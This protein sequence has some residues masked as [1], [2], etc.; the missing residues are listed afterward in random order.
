MP[1][2]LV[3][4]GRAAATVR[5]TTP[6]P[7]SVPL[8]TGPLSRHDLERLAETAAGELIAGDVGTIARLFKSIRSPVPGIRWEPAETDIARGELRF[9]LRLWS[10]RAERGSLPPSW[11]IDPI[12]LRPA[13]GYLMLLEPVD[14]GA[15]FRYRLYGSL[16]AEHS[17]L[18]M[19]GKSVWDIPSGPVAVYLLAT[20]RAVLRARRPMLA[21]HTTHHDIQ[22]AD[23]SRLILPFA[24]EDGGVDRLLVGNVPTLRPA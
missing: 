4:P 18:E 23:W 17:G 13:L 12:E 20:Y 14:A 8:E 15:D 6:S 10:G 1:A 3:P 2:R 21:D 24:G 9:L 7:R 11:S 16:I 5:W 22:I 19:T